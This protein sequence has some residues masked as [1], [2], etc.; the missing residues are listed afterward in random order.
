MDFEKLITRC[1]DKMSEENLTNKD[2][3]HLAQISEAT[4]SRVLSTRGAVAST[5]TITAICDALGIEDVARYE[6]VSPPDKCVKCG[7]CIKCEARNQARIDDLKAVRSSM[8]ILM[9][10]RASRILLS[11]LKI[12]LSIMSYPSLALFSVQS[13]C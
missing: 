10:V 4:V 6:N 9:L 7:T 12:A 13:K 5:A 1:I 2:V 8:S 11:T 3:A